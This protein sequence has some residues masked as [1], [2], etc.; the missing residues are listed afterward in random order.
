MK[1]DK[2]AIKSSSSLVADDARGAYDWEFDL[3][4]C[5]SISWYGSFVGFIRSVLV[6][7]TVM[8]TCLPPGDLGLLVTLKVEIL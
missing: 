5:R 1:S 6:S 4:I 7:R 8:V 3:I 2:D